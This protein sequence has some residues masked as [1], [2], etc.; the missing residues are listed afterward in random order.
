MRASERQTKELT[1]R[2]YICNNTVVLGK[3]RQENQKF[4]KVHIVSSRS[5]WAILDMPKIKIS[6]WETQAVR[7]L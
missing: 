6:I 3:Y 4:S 2:V 5:T 1:M 7:S